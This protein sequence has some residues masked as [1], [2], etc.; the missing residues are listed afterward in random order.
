MS[1][2]SLVVFDVSPSDVLEEAD[3]GQLESTV[4][5]IAMEGLDWKAGKVINVEE[6]NCQQVVFLLPMELKN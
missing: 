2:K 1:E 4:R 6:A 5:A 3:W